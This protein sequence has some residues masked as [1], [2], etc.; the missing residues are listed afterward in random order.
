[1]D[2]LCRKEWDSGVF[3]DDY[4]Y[5]LRTAAEEVGAPLRMVCLLLTGQLPMGVHGKMKE[6]IADKEDINRAVARDLL[7]RYVEL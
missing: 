4:F 7:S 5:E 2:N 3:I 1:M 6:W